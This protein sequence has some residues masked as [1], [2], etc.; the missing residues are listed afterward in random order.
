MD[1]SD[2]NRFSYGISSWC[3][4]WSIGVNKGPQPDKKMTAFE[5][6]D[7]AAAYKVD[8][9]QIA[10]NLRL[11]ELSENEISSLREH[12]DKNNIS[13]EIGTKGFDP[14]HLLNFL[15]LAKELKSPIVRTLPALFGQTAVLEEVERNLIK[16]LPEFEKAGIILV[17][18]NTE[19]FKVKDYTDLIERVNHANFKMCVDLANA[20]GAMEGPEYTMGMF[21]PYCANYHFKDI[22]VI[23]SQSLMGFTVEGMP[24]GQG[25][26]SLPWALDKFREQKLKPS[27]I[28]ELWP[29][30]QETL[31]ETMVLEDRWV[32]ESVDYLKSIDL[33]YP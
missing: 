15:K 33:S 2:T 14:V 10:D 21:L 3:Y 19:T 23:R 27:I 29:T 13:I 20:L 12:A 28:L 26:L 25:E 16:I 7:K 8:I 30:P 17:L 6:I 4:P 31:K 22:R 11:E 18:E 24:A 32:K 1:N 5:L 9:V